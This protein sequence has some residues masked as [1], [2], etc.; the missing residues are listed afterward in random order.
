MAHSDAVYVIHD[1]LIN[2]DVFMFMAQ[3]DGIA[4]GHLHA[5]CNRMQRTDFSLHRV[6]AYDFADQQLVPVDIDRVYVCEATPAFLKDSEDAYI[7][8]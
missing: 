7:E 5:F 4:K 2:A 1:K 8:A 3:H 6:T